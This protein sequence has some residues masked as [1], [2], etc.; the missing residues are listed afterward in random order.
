MHKFLKNNWKLKLVIFIISLTLFLY[1]LDY[2][3]IFTDEVV[4]WDAGRN[5]ILKNEVIAN[6]QHPLI[7]KYIAGL[8]SLPQENNIFL[9]RLPFAVMGAMASVV[10]FAIAAEWLS[11][12]WA[13]F[14][15]LLYLTYPF[16][17][18]SER[19]AMMEAPM[20]LFWLLFNLFFLKYL[21]SKSKKDV[22]ISGVFLG[23]S[24]AT[25]FTSITLIPFIPLAILLYCY[26]NKQKL[27]EYKNIFLIIL[28]AIIVFGLSYTQLIFKRGFYF[29]ITDVLRSNKDIIFDRNSEGK[30]HIIGNKIY[31]KSPWWFY[32]YYIY[33][34]YSIPQIILTIAAT[35]TNF[36]K[37]TFFGAYWGLFL[38]LN[39]VLFFNMGLKNARYI[40]SMEIALV[41][42]VAAGSK[43]LLENIKVRWVRILFISVVI[44][45][46]IL[47]VSNI[48]SMEPTSYNALKNYLIK[49][50]NNFTTGDRTFAYG[51]INSGRWT[52]REYQQYQNSPVLFRKDF[53]LRCDFA[54]F[55]YIVF[56][57]VELIKVQDNELYN[58]INANRELYTEVPMSGLTLFKKKDNVAPLVDSSCYL[59]PNKGFN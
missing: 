49:E 15:C 51:S 45:T 18:S 38:L 36:F 19:M 1:K 46:V 29:A 8:A 14:A 23:L 31:T 56:D 26:L 59:L 40:G 28:P 13:L 24:L 37:K 35:L 41:F 25:K 9:I 52:F 32:F 2:T 58:Y 47:R 3:S 20:H 43:I 17:F 57:D 5:Y 53:E 42:L 11:V 50:T 39:A 27:S 21:K 48:I 33:Q 12:G 6:L 16:I 7:A 55:K 44:A 22:I 30:I 4:Y 10:V 54:D 34:A